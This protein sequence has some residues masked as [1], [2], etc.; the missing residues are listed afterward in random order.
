M[1]ADHINLHKG[2]QQRLER[3]VLS[4]RLD[5]GHAAIGEIAKAR[6][7][8]KTQ[9]PA[10]RED[11]IGRAAGVGV[12]RIDLEPGTVMKQAVK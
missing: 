12:M 2:A 3:R 4:G 7:E 6:A 5:A 1:L 9:H 8:A 11:V 10:Q